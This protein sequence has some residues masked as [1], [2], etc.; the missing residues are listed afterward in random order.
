MRGLCTRELTADGVTGTRSARDQATNILAESPGAREA[1]NWLRNYRKVDYPYDK[2][3]C[4]GSVDG[5][6]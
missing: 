1:P 2:G 6:H 5:Q 4:R 3:W